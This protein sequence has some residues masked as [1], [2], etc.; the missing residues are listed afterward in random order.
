MAK[1]YG[2]TWTLFIQ[3]W[4][5]KWS[6]KY[7]H[8]IECWLV[9]FKHK[10]RWLC[11]SCWEKERDKDPKRKAVKYKAWHKWHVANKPRKPREEWEPMGTKKRLTPEQKK[12]YQ[13][14]WYQKWKEPIIILN[15]WRIWAKKWLILPLYKGRPIPFEIWPRMDDETYEEY[16]ERMRK[17]DLVVKFINK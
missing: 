3:W 16:K 11:T 4:K 6:Q 14:A 13:K 8:C 12:E 5:Y 1:E 15:K 9:K 10:G 7:E 17:F 2:H